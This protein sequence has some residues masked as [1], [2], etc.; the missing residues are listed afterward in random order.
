M[1]IESQIREKLG[2]FLSHE[3]S[4]DQFEDWLVQHSWNMHRDSDE[5]AQKLASAIELRL[6]EHSS[7]HLDD[8]ALRDEL[9]QFVNSYTLHFSF[10]DAMPIFHE[11]SPNNITVEAKALVVAF[12]V[13]LAHQPSPEASALVDRS[14]AV[15]LASGQ[16]F[17]Q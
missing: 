6:A 4:L 2:R 10:N 1:V 12:P 15:E 3:M 7:G 9:R 5:S 16:Y 13:R 14:R 11:E 17:P 8:A